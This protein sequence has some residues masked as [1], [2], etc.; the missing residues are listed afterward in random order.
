MEEDNVYYSCCPHC[1][2]IISWII[3]EPDSCPN[4]HKNYK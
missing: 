1:G 3:N 4:C 2:I